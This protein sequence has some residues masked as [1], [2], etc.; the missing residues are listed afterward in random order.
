VRNRRRE[1]GAEWLRDLEYN[2]LGTD[3][4]GFDLL[5]RLLYGMRLYAYIAV[6]VTII[7]TLIGLVLSS[8]RFMLGIQRRSTF[9]VATVLQSTPM[10]YVLMIISSDISDPNILIAILI[11]IFSGRISGNV[12]G[13]VEEH[14]HAGY[15]YAARALGETRLDIWLRHLRP[16]ASEAAFILWPEIATQC[17]GTLFALDFLGFGLPPS[18]PSLSDILKQ[19]KDNIQ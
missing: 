8:I 4:Q 13:A 14:S 3:D 6:F 16:I 1:E 19:G 2:W 17:L 5:A 15:L 9:V 11:L 7:A 10:L 18:L 12:T